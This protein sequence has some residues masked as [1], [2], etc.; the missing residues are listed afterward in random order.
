[1]GRIVVDLAHMLLR[2]RSLSGL[3][4][5]DAPV[6]IQKMALQSY[7]RSILLDPKKFLPLSLYKWP[8]AYDQNKSKWQER[9]FLSGVQV[10][11]RPPTKGIRG[12]LVR[13]G[14]P[15]NQRAFKA[16]DKAPLSLSL[17][18]FSKLYKKNSRLLVFLASA[19][20]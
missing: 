7:R 19:G 14:P 1:M 18:V 6:P 16:S 11:V 17:N 15:P 4:G 5:L 13:V 2:K 20:H 3:V 8:V 12:V 9:V 10:R